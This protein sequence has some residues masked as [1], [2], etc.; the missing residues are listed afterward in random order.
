[1]KLSLENKRKWQAEVV[2]LAK[3][4]VGTKELKP[5]RLFSK[6]GFI[7]LLNKVG[8]TKGNPYCATFAWAIWITAAENVGLESFAAFLK[9]MK[10]DS[11]IQTWS[12]LDA[13]NDIDTRS[14]IPQVGS[15]VVWRK[16]LLWKGHVG[17]IID[18]VSMT[19]IE[20][21]TGSTNPREG[22]GTYSKHRVGGKIAGMRRL[23]YATPKN[24]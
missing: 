5:N 18:P 14:G 23:G 9:T 22:D 10:S 4:Y 15:I 13:S 17:I 3:S 8:F 20:G 2:R 16:G 6:A 7:D 1:M 24:Y 19:T 12:N 11:S 21:N